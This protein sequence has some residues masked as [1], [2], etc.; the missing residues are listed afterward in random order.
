ME[1]LVL[2]HLPT[3][4]AAALAVAAAVAAITLVAIDGRSPS[5]RAVAVLLMRL[6]LILAGALAGLL[7]AGTSGLGGS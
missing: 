1:A 5:R 4:L 6:A 3:I 7:Q 2:H